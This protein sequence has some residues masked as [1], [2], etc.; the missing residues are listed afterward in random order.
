[1][2]VLAYHPGTGHSVLVDD[3]QLA[4]MRRAG[5]MARSEHDEHEAAKA[6]AAE[7]AAQA[8]AKTDAKAAK[9]AGNA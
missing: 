2:A 1:M 6:A 7:A 8:A 3:A 9:A 4:L 5:W